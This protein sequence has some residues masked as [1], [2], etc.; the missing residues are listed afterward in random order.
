MH[1]G[2]VPLD[3]LHGDRDRAESFGSA[4][5]EYDRYRPG[6]PPALIDE[7]LAESPSNVLDVGC[8][9]GKVAIPLLA[10]G[11]RVLGIEPDL[12]MAAVAREHGVPVEVASFESWEPASRTFGL[13]TAG[14]SWHWVDPVVGLAKAGSVV[15]PGGTIALFWNYHVVDDD[16]LSA[17]DDAYRDHAPELTVVGRDPSGTEDPDPFEDSTQFRSLGS[18]TFRWSRVLNADDWT[19]M[20]GTFSDHARLGHTRLTSLRQALRTA[21]EQRGGVVHS[22]CG[23]YLWMARRVEGSSS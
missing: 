7:L 16:L 11:L 22:E 15:D 3:G 6:Y 17:F 12:R 20:L 21:I 4:A 9:T 19:S 2:G 1:T 13:L 5:E 18:R 14:H 23:T 10:R 8:G